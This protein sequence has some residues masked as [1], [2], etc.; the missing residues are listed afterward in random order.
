MTA[1]DIVAGERKLTMVG[2][3]QSYLDGH[4]D[5][6]GDLSPVSQAM[7][8]LP[9]DSV[10]IDVGANVGF[11]SCAL[12]A[13]RPDLRIIAI[14]PV[15]HNVEALRSNVV[16]NGLTNI[17]VMH[18]GVSD[19]PAALRFTSQ[20][21]WSSVDPNGE[22]EVQCVTLDDFENLN[23]SGI[24]IDV[25]GWE[26]HVLAGAGALLAQR[27]LIHM[28]FNLWWVLVRHNDALSLLK[29]IWSNTEMI[30]MYV[31]EKFLPPPA[32]ETDFLYLHLAEHRGVSDLLFRPRGALGTLDSLT[33][34]PDHFALRV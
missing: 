24:K 23:V 7:K 29:A 5:W 8:D 22:V 21:P 11:I 33:L 20:G 25:E 32:N 10:F 18:A 12:A 26:S 6:N 34:P 16:A 2:P 28:E 3:I 30:G 9:Q 27:P 31:D 14:E 1:I 19:K 13:I 4:K 17:E 15:P